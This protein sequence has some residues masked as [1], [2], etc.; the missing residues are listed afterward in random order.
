MPDIFL[1]N[2]PI[3]VAD[4]YGPLGAAGSFAPPLGLCYLA[5]YLRVSGFTVELIDGAAGNL[6]FAEIGNAVEGGAICIGI[7]ATTSTIAIAGQLAAYLKEKV[8]SFILIGGAHLSALPEETM[9]LYPF[10]IGVI[11]EGEVTTVELLTAIKAGKGFAD[12]HGVVYRTSEGILC[13]TPARSLQRELDSLGFPAFDLLKGYPHRY[14][15]QFQS[16]IDYP[17]V[18]L[19]TSRGCTGRCTFCDR[20]IFGNHVRFHSIDYLIELIDQLVSMYGIRNI[21]FEDDNFMISANRVR[22]FCERLIEAGISIRWS[23]LSR[24]DT[25]DEQ[26]LRLMKAAGCWQI[27]YGIESG[28]ETVLNRL[29]KGIDL[30]Q[31][32]QA[33]ALT[34]K[35]GLKSK[36]FFIFGNPEETEESLQKTMKLI[37]TIPLH[38]VSI[39]LFTPFPGSEIYTE[40]R[41]WGRFDAD[42]CL[43]NFYHSVFIPTGLEEAK[44][45]KAIKKTYFKFYLRFRVVADYLTRSKNPQYYFELIKIGWGMV[46]YLLSKGGVESEES[47]Q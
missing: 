18:S 44:L 36:G 12:V 45:E 43:A 47:G 34:K 42:W 14:R 40:I 25:V 15:L 41:R 33:I 5:G 9:N 19:I 46:R 1:I 8:S 24:V 2:P 4:R 21:Q 22:Q 17:S 28:D 39:C 11:G 27:M 13:R 32:V 16:V 35:A 31:I 23:C 20:T 10:D 29:Q 37:L 30:Q 3:T 38:D 7:T 6:T 26:L